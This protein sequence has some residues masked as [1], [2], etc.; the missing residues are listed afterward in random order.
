MQFAWNVENRY[1]AFILIITAAVLW[2][3]VGVTIR[4]LTDF[5]FTSIQ[6]VVLRFITAA[7]C[8]GLYIAFTNRRKFRI[9]KADVKYFMAYSFFVLLAYSLCFVAAITL[10]SYATATG[11]LYTSP[12]WAMLLS[13]YMFKEKL[14]KRKGLAILLSF[15]GCGLITGLFS[16]GGLSAAPVALL[17]GLGAGMGYGFQGVFTKKFMQKYTSVT[18]VFYY[19][20]FA[21]IFGLPLSDA[22]S[23]GKAFAGAPFSLPVA[24]F[25]AIICYV[26]P[27]ALYAYALNF[28]EA[29]K[30]AVIV[31]VEPVVAALIGFLIYNEPLT[32]AVAFG[33][34]LIISAVVVLYEPASR[35]KPENY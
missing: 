6:I 31:S 11:L 35:A 27:F 13:I 14:T 9:E 3:A 32:A 21:T 30:A 8:F 15:T 1:I 34:I 4:V 26:V 16:G 25:G 2:G 19:F 22:G 33:V 18:V 20:L 23:M 7:V 29:S 24:V 17:A 5:G 28:I 12:I 10:A